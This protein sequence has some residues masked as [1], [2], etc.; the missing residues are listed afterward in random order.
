MLLCGGQRGQAAWE[1]AQGLTHAGS[2]YYIDRHLNP[3]VYHINRHLNPKPTW[4]RSRSMW[5]MIVRSK[6]M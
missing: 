2:V 1:Q 4:P 5:Y 6:V 3:S